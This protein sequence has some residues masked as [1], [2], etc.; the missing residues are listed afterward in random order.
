MPDRQLRFR[1][2]EIVWFD[3]GASGWSRA[4]DA[5]WQLD[6]DE[7]LI[8]TVTSQSLAGLPAEPRTDVDRRVDLALGWFERSQLTTDPIVELLYLFF[9]LETV[10][11]DKSE[12]LKAPAL[13]IRR[14]M[15]G[16]L[17]SGG[18]RHPAHTFLLYDKVRS[19]AVHGE[20]PPPITAKEVGRFAWDVRQALNEYVAF[21][22]ER[23]LTK[24]SQVRAALDDDERRETL[25]DGLKRDDPELWQR[26][27]DDSTPLRLTVVYED[28][29]GD[30]VVA[31]LREIPAAEGHGA[32]REEARADLIAHLGGLTLT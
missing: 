20:E 7:Q 21:T 11:G 26:Y 28:A 22:R 27:L 3:D 13:A 30:G 18:F 31:R 2:G 4:A 10:L 15:L 12:G 25:N 29:G 23:G 24:R 1:L 5:G 32:T 9:A 16:L 19:A 6:I 8:R 17:Q 14:A